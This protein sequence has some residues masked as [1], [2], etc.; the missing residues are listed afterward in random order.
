MM[1]SFSGDEWLNQ[2]CKDLSQL[3]RFVYAF[4]QIF[5]EKPPVVSGPLITLLSAL[6]YELRLVID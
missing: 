5:I 2:A 3:I 6:M 1:K 4:S